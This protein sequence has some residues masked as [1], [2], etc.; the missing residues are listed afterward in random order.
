M[1]FSYV[2]AW[3]RCSYGIRHTQPG[4]V[5][6]FSHA[7]AWARCSCGVHHTRRG[8]VAVFSHAF[9]WARCSCGGLVVPPPVTGREVCLWREIIF[10]VFLL[11]LGLQ[12]IYTPTHHTTP[13]ELPSFSTAESKTRKK[14]IVTQDTS[15][16]LSQRKW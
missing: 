14:Q 7:F 11:R 3:A 10:N 13:M 16:K 6:V 4:L 15:E 8:L 12:P 5:A 1:V 2:F 9:T